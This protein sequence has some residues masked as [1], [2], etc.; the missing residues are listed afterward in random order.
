MK[1]SVGTLIALILAGCTSSAT[2][3]TGPRLGRPG[4]TPASPITNRSAGLEVHGTST[5]ASLYGLLMPA[6]P[7]PI[8]ADEQVKIVW[9]MTGH[10]PLRLTQTSPRGATAP[11]QW[12]PELHSGSN[13]HRPGGEWGAG[14][15]FTTA[16]CWRLHAARGSATADVWLRVKA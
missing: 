15:R 5:D 4:C 10:G 12:G 3:L 8:R 16:G 13:Y 11:P 9:R 2:H 7:V 14:Y 1:R 6:G